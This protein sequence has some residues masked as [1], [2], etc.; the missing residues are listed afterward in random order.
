MF[1]RNIDKKYCN[2]IQQVVTLTD[3]LAEK[4]NLKPGDLSYMTKYLVIRNL[5][6]ADLLVMQKSGKRQKIRLK[7]KVKSY[8]V[9][10]I[11]ELEGFGE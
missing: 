5:V 11:K 10:R 3:K 4:F 6:K 9:E 1:I 7:Q 2:S 8:A